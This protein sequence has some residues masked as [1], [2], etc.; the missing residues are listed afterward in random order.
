MRGR[1]PSTA[2]ARGQGAL[3]GAAAA[4]VA[5][6]ATAPVWPDSGAL[7][8][9]G[10]MLDSLA[11]QLLGAALLAAAGLAALGARGL[12]TLAAAAAFVAGLGLAAGHLSRAA[13]PLAEAA[14]PRVLWFNVLKDNPT[15]PATLAAA[16]AASPADL[17]IL[18]EAA[19]LAGQ[20]AALAAAFPAQA[21][22]RD[23][24][25][26][27][28]L[29]ARDPAATLTL[30]PVGGR[31]PERLASARLPRPGGGHW[32]VLAA[33]HWKPW[34][35][36][37]VEHDRWHLRH[38][39]GGLTGPVLV[40]GDFNAAPWSQPMRALTRDC[41]LAPPRRPPPTWPAAAGR[42]GVPIDL[43]LVGGGAGIAGLAPWGAG[44]GSNH[45]GLIL[46]LGAA[47]PAT[48]VPPTCAPWQRGRA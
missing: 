31:R 48:P 40:V 34:F 7:G 19:P 27:L 8:P 33:H 25:C 20:R 14:G 37:L 26:E 10:R 9:P 39:L 5:L 21:G 11:P 3:A 28:L 35:Q 29:L 47:G 23:A 41:A 24:R 4:L 32:T 12:G 22:C 17:V 30:H 44:L 13:P 43:A 15:P 2:R 42:F 46:R 38:H 16:L 1:A 36:G 18:A 45:R 6:A